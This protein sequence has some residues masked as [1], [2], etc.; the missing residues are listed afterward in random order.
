MMDTMGRAQAILA[1]N[2]HD[3]HV[4]ATGRLWATYQW[5][6]REFSGE[7]SEVLDDVS[8]EGLRGWMGY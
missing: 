3:S 1:V 7:T 6:T 4:D 8:R 5:S 2:G